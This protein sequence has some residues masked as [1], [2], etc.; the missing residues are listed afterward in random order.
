MIYI[1]TFAQSFV[2]GRKSPFSFE[3][4]SSRR[5]KDE[6]QVLFYCASGHGS[7]HQRGV[8]DGHDLDNRLEFGIPD[9]S[10]EQLRSYPNSCSVI[11]AERW[12]S[13][14]RVP[15]VCPAASGEE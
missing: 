8:L 2:L 7:G 4:H 9:R 15:A 6:R 5:G 3:L 14:P 1:L 10:P 12:G 11:L 13:A